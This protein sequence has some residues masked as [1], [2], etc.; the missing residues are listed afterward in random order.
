[1]PISWRRL[2]PC[3][4]ASAALFIAPPVASAQYFGSGLSG[5]QLRQLHQLA[6]PIVV[7]VPAPA[8]FRV[9]RVTS[10]NYDKSYKIVYQSKTGATMV[11]EG[12]QLYGG[13]VQTGPA[14]AAAATVAPTAAPKRGLLQKIFAGAPAA[15]HATVTPAGG[16]SS[17]AEGQGT[18]AIMADS[19]LVGPIRFAPAGPCLQ[20]IADS[21]KAQIHGLRV[22]VSGCNFDNP[23]PLIAAYKNMHRV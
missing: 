17:E 4:V 7:P 2:L 10:S 1:V 14:P 13:A 9:T 5:D 22:T 11:F 6:M 21:S 18:A 19:Q 23:D 16:T 12:R 3:F 20:G 8:G 15:A